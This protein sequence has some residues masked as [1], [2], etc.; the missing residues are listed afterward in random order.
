MQVL[1]RQFFFIAIDIQLG[2]L[3]LS[4]SFYFLSKLSDVHM[5]VKYPFIFKTIS[6]A[7][8]HAPQQSIS[9]RSL[10]LKIVQEHKSLHHQVTVLSCCQTSIA[11]LAT[12]PA[13]Q[14]LVAAQQG[15]LPL[16][17]AFTHA[18]GPLHVELT[19]GDALAELQQDACEP[20]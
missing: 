7:Y 11:C 5:P 18:T 6:K 4:V 9:T 15:L 20:E 14:P 12:S 1:F 10:A 8:M 13:E 19:V 16:L 3:G 17:A 2:T